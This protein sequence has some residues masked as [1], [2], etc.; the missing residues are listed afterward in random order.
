M[1]MRTIKLILQYDGTGYRGW[2]VQREG[3]T[4]QGLLEE[5]LARIT[6]E[7]NTVIGAGRTDAGVHALGQVAAFR[8][9]SPLPPEVFREALN[10]RLPVDIRVVESCAAQ[11][12]FH[13]RF[14][15]ASKVY[16]YIIARQ[17]VLS[18][19]LHRYAW[20][21]PHA[22]DVEALGRAL[23]V[24]KGTHDFSAF[25]ASGC[26]A[27][28]PVRTIKDASVA[29]HAAIE[30]MTVSLQGDFIKVRIEGDAFLRHMVRAI[31]GT[32]VEVGRGKIRAE[33]MEEILRAGDRAL[34]G[35]TAPAQG[36]FL[37][38][39]NYRFACG[40][41]PPGCPPLSCRRKIG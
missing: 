6:G 4:V 33:D 20:R 39:I 2:Q 8:T 19:F 14:D 32:L 13:P 11:E 27:S 24:L 30:F 37:E 35:P 9:A 18:P 17:R 21:V 41:R 10:A 38:R 15:A 23:A 5:A 34:A 36:L 28:G 31:V 1:L 40:E 12:G 25:R 22:L 29:E 3:L 16:F 26:G 7:R